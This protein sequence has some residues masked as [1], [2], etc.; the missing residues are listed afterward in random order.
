[1]DIRY[2][3]NQRD[4]KR[5][6]T[7]ELRDEFL[8]DKLFIED[9]ILATYSH[10]D[11]V[12]VM[13]AMPVN[14]AIN[15]EKNI[16]CSKHLG[17]EYFLERRELGIINIG[18]P[19][20]VIV[21]DKEYKLEKLYG[22]YVGKESKSVIFKSNSSLNPAKF[23]MCS[24]PA[25]KKFETKLITL[26]NA[27]KLELGSLEAS[28]KRVIYQY[29]HPAVLETC[30]LSMG[31]TQLEKGCVW[32]SMPCHTHERRMEVYLYFDIYE[33]NVVFHFM[34]EPQQMRHIV[35]RNEQ[36]VISPSW[37]IHCGCGTSNYS[38]IWSMAGENRT[39]TDMDNI[40]LCEL[41]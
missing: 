40:N 19:G 25:H 27:N 2:G 8:I 26:E 23:Y 22:L 16:E 14:N 10:T 39:F 29:I 36:A 41:K 30:Q 7:E 21:D 6:D 3:A 17:V 20:T 33:D 1:M 35:M 4:V 28:N 11:R 37:S 12:I 15:L 9:D 31:C 18:G 24:T 13:G 38:F 34:G 5:Y 32:N